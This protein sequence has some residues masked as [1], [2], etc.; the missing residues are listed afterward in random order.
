M[1][2]YIA[3]FKG[4]NVYLTD[5]DHYDPKD[6]DTI[7]VIEVKGDNTYDVVQN[8]M[9]MGYYD[10]KT[11]EITSTTRLSKYPFQKQIEKEIKSKDWMEGVDDMGSV[12]GILENFETKTEEG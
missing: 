5:K 11:G 8:G 12:E 2:G 10:P 6:K 3:N 4:V 7:Y 1:K 9:I